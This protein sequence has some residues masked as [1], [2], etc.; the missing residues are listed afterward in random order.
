MNWTIQRKLYAMVAALSA[1]LLLLGALTYERFGRTAEIEDE[2]NSAHRI[3]ILSSEMQ[4]SMLEAR[5]RE[6]DFFARQGDM[7]Y[8]ELVA[9]EG[10][11][12]IKIGTEL[13]QLVARHRAEA[14][15]VTG[16]A[17]LDDDMKEYLAAFEKA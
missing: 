11:A 9:K 7:K 16:L 6:K 15:A 1:L 13:K 10:A 2:L 3:E 17:S 12:F 8:R 14:R 4:R 5:R